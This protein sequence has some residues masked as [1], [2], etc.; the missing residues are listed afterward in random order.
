MTLARL[1]V[2]AVAGLVASAIWHD[3]RGL[4][5]PRMRLLPSCT[6]HPERLS[7]GERMSCPD[8]RSTP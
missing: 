3:L 7:V 6:W 8:M 1:I 2:A 5:P 4:P